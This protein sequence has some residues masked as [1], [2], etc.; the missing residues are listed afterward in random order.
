MSSAPNQADYVLHLSAKTK[1]AISDSCDFE[2][3][4]GEIYSPFGHLDYVAV[5]NPSTPQSHRRVDISF[6]RNIVSG[7]YTIGAP[8]TPV[9]RVGYV[10]HTGDPTEHDLIEYIGEGVVKVKVTP[11]GKNRFKYKF[12]FSLKV[13]ASDGDTLSFAGSS[14]LCIWFF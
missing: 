7:Q 4:S 13:I 5:E 2:S 12:A 10:I 8:S 11:L 1:V 14:T 9:H 3:V 6:D